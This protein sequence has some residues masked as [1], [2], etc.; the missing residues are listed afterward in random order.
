MTRS[1]CT[2][3]IVNQKQYHMP[4]GI[5]EISA[6]HHQEMEKGRGGNSHL[7]LPIWPEKKMDGSQRKTVGYCNHLVL[8]IPIAV[9]MP[10]VVSLL[11]QIQY[12][13]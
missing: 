8:T 9:A 7:I 10:D 11:Q 12:I 6:T 1:V 2:W 5:V 3:E 13:S 4:G